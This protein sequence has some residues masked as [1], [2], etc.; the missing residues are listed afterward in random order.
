MKCWTPP[1][2]ER[3]VPYR[4]LHAC[5]SCIF[6]AL[7]ALLTGL[8]VS[9]TTGSSLLAFAAA[10]L[11]A[12]LVW[13]DAAAAARRFVLNRKRVKA[14]LLRVGKFLGL[15]LLRY[16]AVPVVALVAFALARVA[17][18]SAA[19]AAAAAGLAGATVYLLFRFLSD[20]S[21][22]AGG[23][24]MITVEEAQLRVAARRPIGDPGFRHGKVL[25][26]TDAL[27]YGFLF[28]GAPRSGKGV[29]SRLLLQFAILEGPPPDWSPAEARKPSRSPRSG[30]DD[31]W[32]LRMFCYDAKADEYLRIL[33]AIQ[34]RRVAAGK[35]CLPIYVLNP[36]DTPSAA[37]ASYG[38]VR[39]VRWDVA[40]SCHGPANTLTIARALA[41]E[42]SSDS[43]N[44]EF[45]HGAAVEIIR[46]TLAALDIACRDR[47]TLGEAMACLSDEWCLYWLVS[48]SP[49]TDRARKFFPADYPQRCQ[50]DGSSGDVLRTILQK[51]APLMV[52]AA[53]ND[54]ATT[55][56]SLDDWLRDGGIL[57]CPV[58]QSL[59]GSTEPL[60]AALFERLASSVLA[61]Q[62]EDSGPLWFWLDEAITFRFPSLRTLCSMGFGKGAIPVL[63]LQSL[64]A[65][66]K[67]YGAEDAEAIA[68][69]LRNVSV[70][71][72]EEPTT[73][74]HLKDRFGNE[75][76]W[77]EV[78]RTA[79]GRHLD[80]S[81]L[82]SAD[83]VQQLP[84]ATRAGGVV[85]IFATPVLE[86]ACYQAHSTQADLQRDLIDAL[87]KELL[88]D[89]TRAPVDHEQLPTL[90]ATKRKLLGI[91][92]RP[93]GGP[94]TAD[95]PAVTP[96]SSPSPAPSGQAAPRT[97]EVI[98]HRTGQREQRPI[99]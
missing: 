61:P 85:G 26:P 48:R 52:A 90:S 95:V 25:L 9:R 86:G 47:W 1:M 83:D 13:V 51:L 46:C 44:A 64:A 56:L 77:T 27:K 88:P 75:R 28:L 70:L 50:L 82:I 21:D 7:F 91:P 34:Q 53:L 78:D 45:F 59:A 80:T 36:F 98:D 94:V 22:H 73:L 18:G 99:P 14:G 57:L 11:A 79:Q 58:D 67:T 74:K 76:Y 89:C 2:A 72:V 42:G 65:F 4:F 84:A 5:A 39:G 96:P 81:E 24:E 54:H 3:H 60:Y 29:V 87:P 17:F 6:P 31:P 23:M 12:F 66:G 63:A 71:P 93:G 33:A 19:T 35:K 68:G 10:P 20:L 43:T 97:I 62:A 38:I 92:D 69:M 55:A 16:L 32:P 40:R 15:L 41:P 8:V 30:G 49:Y 37:D